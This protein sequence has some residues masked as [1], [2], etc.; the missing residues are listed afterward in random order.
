ME[1]LERETKQILK[2]NGIYANKSL[3][4]NFLIREE[5]VEGIIQ[6][7]GINKTDAVIEIGPGLRDINKIFIAR[8]WASFG[9]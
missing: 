5:I 6:K 3:G 7:A 4:Q 9:D 2:E 1:L 8:S